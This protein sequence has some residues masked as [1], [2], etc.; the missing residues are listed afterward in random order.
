MIKLYISK[1]ELNKQEQKKTPKFE[2]KEKQ[3]NPTV[4]PIDKISP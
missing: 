4:Q 3:M 1:S 2:Q